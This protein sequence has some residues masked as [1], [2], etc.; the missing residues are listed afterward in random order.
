MDKAKAIEVLRIIERLASCELEARHMRDIIELIERRDEQNRT[1]AHCL[2]A[3]D[4]IIERQER[5]IQA[6]IEYIQDEN[7]DC[8][9]NAGCNCIEDDNC[10]GPCPLDGSDEQAEKCWRRWLEGAQRD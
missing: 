5:M 2:A 9:L 1:Q 7:G 6:A 4:R 10:P 3:R 8:P